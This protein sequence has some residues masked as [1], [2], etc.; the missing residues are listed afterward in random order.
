MKLREEIFLN[1]AISSQVLT[2]SIL[3]TQRIFWYLNILPDP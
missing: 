3:K 1:M 2:W